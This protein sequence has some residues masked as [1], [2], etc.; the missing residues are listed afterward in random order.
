MGNN[1]IWLNNTS[2]L[3]CDVIDFCA[4]LV[5]GKTDKQSRNKICAGL[6]KKFKISE[7]NPYRNLIDYNYIKQLAP[8]TQTQLRFAQ[9]RLCLGCLGYIKGSKYNSILYTAFY[10]FYVYI[11]LVNLYF[12]ICINLQDFAKAH[13]MEF[14][15][16]KNILFLYQSLL[17]LYEI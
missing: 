4:K 6:M 1:Q 8:Q 2:F 7:L 5:F 14:S 3:L 9:L 17:F 11:A 10:L 13:Y 16:V 15:E 12:K